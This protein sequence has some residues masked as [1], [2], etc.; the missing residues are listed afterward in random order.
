M[1]FNS[2]EFI[3]LFLPVAVGGYFFFGRLGCQASNLWLTFA[4]LFFYGWWDVRYLPLLIG[5]IAVNYVVAGRILSMRAAGQTARARAVFLFGLVI[6]LGLLGWYKYLDFFLKNL[7]ALTGAQIPLL[8]LVLPLGISFFT[9]TQVLYLYDCYEG[10][11]KDHD[12]VRYALFVSFFPHLMAGPILYHRQMMQQL[13]DDALHHPRWDDLARGSMLFLLGLAKKVLIAD[14]FIQYVDPAFR[15][16]GNLTFLGSWLVM[17]C[18][19]CQLYF[20]FSGYSDMAVGLARMMGIAIPI[21]FNAPYRAAS[22]ITFWQRWHISLTNA[23]TACVYMPLVRCFHRPTV[24]V[25]TGAATFTLFV[26]GIWHGAGWHYVIFAAMHAA[27]I[28]VNHIWRQKKLPMPRP[29]GHILTLLWVTLAMVF[30]RAGSAGDGATVLAAMFGLH[31][32]AWPA[33][34]VA[35]ASHFGLVLDW[36]PVLY[37]FP[38][39]IFILAVLLIAFAPPSHQMVKRLRL[40]WSVFCA[41]AALFLAAL[42]QL[43]T[44][45]SFLY[46]QF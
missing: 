14:S 1:L 40:T 8:H 45:T 19:L 6:D 46:F 41:A 15:A 44:A 22:L 27:G 17:A 7:D 18:Y 29:L 10:V 23:L 34:L 42:Y 9:I 39:K 12:L 24:A 2:Y 35:A 33:T 36:Q 30:F 38:K 26:V 28:A 31:G 21:N 3:F 11:A 37:Q 5:S 25:T 4:S 13:A 16:P 20:D 43:G 32:F